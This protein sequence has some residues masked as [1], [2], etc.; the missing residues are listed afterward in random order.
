M[1]RADRLFEIVQYLRGGRLL[2]AQ[3]LAERL[4]VSKRTI[5][6][7]LAHLQAC[8]VPIEGEAGVGY[9]LSSDYHV[10]P[11]T[12]TADEITALVL[13]ARMVKAWASNDLTKAAEEA[14][15]KIDAVIPEGMRK[16][17][18]DTQMYAMSFSDGN[19]ERKSL[20]ALRKACKERR[21]L[22]LDYESLEQAATQRL[23]RPLGLY[24]W[25][26]VWTLLAW[27]ELRD[28]FRTFRVD[29]I[30]SWKQEERVFSH[31]AG[32]E[33]RD[34]V[35]MMEERSKQGDQTYTVKPIS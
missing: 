27:C 8:G 9:V 30:A 1:R 26:R 7:D 18:D 28:D 25:G 12:F 17:L 34:Y 33:L 19:R 14:L 20:D 5:Y 3:I 32:K 13:G 16:L 29:R 35:L 22:V 10:P 23:V 21:Y 11:L 24:F 4:E 15:V 6:R 31:E 2:T